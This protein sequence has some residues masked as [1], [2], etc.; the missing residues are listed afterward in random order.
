LELPSYEQ[1]NREA[2]VSQYVGYIMTMIEYW[3][4]GSDSFVRLKRILD[5][6]LQYI[7]LNNDK[8]T[9]LDLYEIIISIQ[10]DSKDILPKMFKELGKPDAVLQQAIESIAGMNREAYEPVLN[11]VE[12]FATDPILRHL[13]CVRESTINFKDLIEAGNITIIRLSPLNIPQHI[14][15]LAKQT[16]IIKLWFTIQERAEKI[17]AEEDRSQVILALDEFQD[18]A[19]LPIIESMLTQARSYKLSLLLAHQTSTQL[20]NE[21][22]EI[23]TG[24]VGTQFV[25][26]AVS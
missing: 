12:K 17:K 18:V 23:I 15:T 3:Y 11:R 13:F 8:P 2:I 21:L 19:E 1:E 4:N 5:T 14:I 16:L 25:G 26:R 20:N 7:Y 9:F 24:N 6:L 10:E 22:F